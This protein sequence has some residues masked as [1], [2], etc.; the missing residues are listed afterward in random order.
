MH[1]GKVALW[2]DGG[3]VDDEGAVRRAS[4][5]PCDWKDLALIGC[6]SVL[7]LWRRG[8]VLVLLNA[9]SGLGTQN[10]QATN[11]SFGEDKID[12]TLTKIYI[13]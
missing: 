5:L 12:N 8:P 4:R 3:S 1:A 2:R 10:R 9:R 11:V 7:L 13:M 6:R